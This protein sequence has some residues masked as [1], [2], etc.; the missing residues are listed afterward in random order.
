MKNAY[1]IR[2]S[3][4]IIVFILIILGFTCKFY[5][6]KVLDLQ[7][8]PVLQR[9][10]IDFSAFAIVILIG[11]IAVTAL[12]GR[13]YC[14]AICPFGIL[15]DLAG[16]IFRRKNKFTPNYP[17]K[18]FVAALTF[19]ALAGGSAVVLRYIEPYTILGSAITVTVLSLITTVA[20]LV[21]MFFKNRFFCT[22]IC[23]VGALLGL[24][25]KFSLNKIYI[26]QSLCVSCGMCEKN[27]SSGCINSKEKSIDNETCVKCLK[28]LSVC[29]KG[30]IKFGKEQK[31]K[32]E[33]KFSLKRRQLIIG[34]AVVALFGGMVKAGMVLK[35]KVVEKIKDIILPAGAESK[36]RFLNK[37]FNCN[38]C[39]A[40]C[41]SKIL[42][43]AD[44]SFG[45][46]HIDYSKGFCKYDCAKCGEVCPT[47]AIKRLKL[48]EK[49]KTRIA[50]AMIIEDKCNHCGAC[51]SICPRG[52]IIKQDGKAPVLNAQKCIGCG[53]CKSTCWHEAIELFPIK[54]QRSI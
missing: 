30:G 47:G 2:L 38:L 18:Y 13:I 54:E 17:V 19:G 3:A 40:N 23:P 46:V 6:V 21:L 37:C 44:E 34:T 49:Q 52:A 28:C 43:K 12:F 41:P 16:L 39:V 10:F 35:D 26:N 9:V 31:V 25:S 32:S 5:P 45:A 20:V 4:A 51:A 7:L 8:A 53:A 29:P 50:M 27:C 24:I 22:N 36:E 1:K 14:S 42:V 15:Q 33:V 11:I 48:E